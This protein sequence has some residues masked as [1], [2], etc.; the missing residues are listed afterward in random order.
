MASGFESDMTMEIFI[1][2]QGQQTGPF[3]QQEIQEGL[4]SGTYQPS[5]L[6]WYEGAAGWVPLSNA[7]HLIDSTPQLPTAIPTGGQ[8]QNSGL[9]ITSMILGISTPL[10]GITAIPAVICGHIAL[11]KIKRSQGSLSGGG[12]AI[13]GLITGYLGLIVFIAMLA[14]LATPMV[15]RQRK[16]ADQ[17]EAISNA[18]QIGL[19]LFEFQMEYGSFPNSRT[20]PLVADSSGTPEI[21]GASSN[22]RFRQLLRS[23]NT[24]SEALFYAKADGIQRPDNDISGDQALAPGECAFGYIDNIRTNDSPRPIAMAPFIPGSEEFDPLPYGGKAVVLWSDNSVRPLNI[25]RATGEAI[26]DGQNLLDPTHPVWG[27]TAP[28]LLL[29]E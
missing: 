21:T 28:T 3:T 17:T 10:C 16:L 4:T 7:L 20:A 27:G 2:H 24:Q 18:R 11:G 25:N 9:A 8:P 14:G 19:S 23:G 15:L 1:Q 22:A 5:D 29:P 12:F 6:I 26:L 13:A